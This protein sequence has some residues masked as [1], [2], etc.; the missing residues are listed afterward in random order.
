MERE[1]SAVDAV[2]L[3]LE[4]IE[5]LEKKISVIDDNLKIL[6]NKITKINKNNN[7]QSQETSKS[8]PMAVTTNQPSKPTDDSNSIKQNEPD[9][10]V[11]GPVKV[12]GVIINKMREPI[13]DVIINLFDASNKLIKSTKTDQ[14]GHWDV[15]VPSGRYN[16]EYTHSKFK[17]I[18]KEIEIPKNTKE[19]EVK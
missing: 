18:N 8:M 3:I 16:I 11:L 15:R 12:Y 5:L 1:Y 14:N 2:F 7:I 6:N 17:S 19:Y 9:K 10:L 13:K 4:K